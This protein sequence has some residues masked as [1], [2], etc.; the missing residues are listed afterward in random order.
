HQAQIRAT[1]LVTLPED[2]AKCRN[3]NV[4]EQIV[5]PCHREFPGAPPGLA[6]I[7]P[8][9]TFKSEYEERILLNVFLKGGNPLVTHRPAPTYLLWL[10]RMRNPIRHW[11]VRNCRLGGSLMAVVTDEQALPS[12]GRSEFRPSG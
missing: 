12:G 5:S 1:L 4:T 7:T 11:R 6:Q 2:Q 9:F 8:F 10:E 3:L